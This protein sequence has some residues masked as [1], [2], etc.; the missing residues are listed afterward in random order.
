[1]KKKKKKS[2]LD[3]GVAVIDVH[4]IPGKEGEGLN[5]KSLSH[6][7]KEGGMQLG[8]QEQNHKTYSKRNSRRSGRRQ[9]SEAF[10]GGLKDF[11]DGY[12]R[13]GVG[14][15]FLDW[16]E[17]KNKQNEVGSNTIWRKRQGE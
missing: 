14:S 11:L 5:Y 8:G 1:M 4:R 7:P 17:S 16:E 3:R 9:R 2:K 10:L 12:E 6:W 15:P 13:I